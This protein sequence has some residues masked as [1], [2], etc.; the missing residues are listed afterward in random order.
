MQGHVFLEIVEPP[1]A[2][3]TQT[4]RAGRSLGWD[5]ALQISNNLEN[6]MF[7]EKWN[8]ACKNQVKSHFSP[9]T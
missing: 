6:N 8:T 7:L 5:G 4:H 2:A 3:A 1:Q 9:K